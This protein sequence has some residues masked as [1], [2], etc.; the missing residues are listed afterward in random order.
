MSPPRRSRGVPRGHWRP[1]GSGPRN[2]VLQRSA[3]NADSVTMAI[4]QAFVMATTMLLI[5]VAWRI[6]FEVEAEEQG[7]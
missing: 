3:P 1:A 5:S 4:L 6:T 7:L 2:F